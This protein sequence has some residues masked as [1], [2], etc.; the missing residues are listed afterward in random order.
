MSDRPDDL[1]I[2]FR[3]TGGLAGVPLEVVG[4]VDELDLPEEVRARLRRLAAGRGDGGVA[5]GASTPDGF[6]YVLRLG[7]PGGDREL[8]WSDATLPADLAS[9]VAALTHL[10]LPPSRGG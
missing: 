8:R 7:A 6:G 1:R 5:S 10:A 2:T 3:R 4:S 9:V